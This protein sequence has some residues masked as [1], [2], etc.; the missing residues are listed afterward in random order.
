MRMFAAVLA[1]LLLGLAGGGVPGGA[2]AGPSMSEGG[3]PSPRERLLLLAR[4][5]GPAA[6][7]VSTGR[8]S[9]IRLV[10]WVRTGAVVARFDSERWRAADGSGRLAELRLDAPGAPVSRIDYPPGGLPLHP[11]RPGDGPTAVATSLLDTI[12][13]RYLDRAERAAAL[14]TLAGLPGL[15]YAGLTESGLAFTLPAGDAPLTIRVSPATGEVTGWQYG[16]AE[17]VEVLARDR[18]ASL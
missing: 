2:V 11:A 12:G 7:D 16:D 18:V 13:V 1:G 15:A 10:R 4:A 8:Y 17:R 6:G 5:A 9:R 14:R 3:P